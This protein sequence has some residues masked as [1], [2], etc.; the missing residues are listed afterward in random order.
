MIAVINDING[1]PHKAGQADKIQPEKVHRTSIPGE[2]NQIHKNLS[3]RRNTKQ[4]QLVRCFRYK[5]LYDNVLFNY[6]VFFLSSS[7]DHRDYH[8]YHD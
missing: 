3:K 6:Q 7:D 2:I 8:D 4:K 1:V 5:D